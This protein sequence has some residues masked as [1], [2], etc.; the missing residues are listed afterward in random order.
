[1]TIVDQLAFD[2]RSCNL[3]RRIS[4]G[5]IGKLGENIHYG[6]FSAIQSRLIRLSKQDLVRGAEESIQDVR[7]SCEMLRSDY[8]EFG[9]QPQGMNYYEKE[10]AELDAVHDQFKLRPDLDKNRPL[11][12]LQKLPREIIT[13]LFLAT[14][15]FIAIA[16][17]ATTNTALF[18][19]GYLR[20]VALAQEAY[21]WAGDRLI[22]VGDYCRIDDAPEGVFSATEAAELGLKGP[23]TGQDSET[24]EGADECSDT[25]NFYEAL[26]NAMT[27]SAPSDYDGLLQPTWASPG[28]VPDLRIRKMLRTLPTL[29]RLLYN[30]LSEASTCGNIG[31]TGKSL[32]ANKEHPWVLCN[33]TTGEY[34]RAS[35][36][37]KLRFQPGDDYD[38]ASLDYGP[39]VGRRLTLST[40]V[41]A[42]F[43]RSSD[44]SAA[45]AYEGD[46]HR[47]VWAGHRFEIVS[48]D[49]VRP[50]GDGREWKDVSEE[51]AEEMKALWISEFGDEWQKKL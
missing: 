17:L 31:K 43:C 26:S 9:R 10:V 4:S 7:K 49:S 47:G 15:D 28:K 16:C 51:V 45:M 32:L 6:G 18:Q 40:V 13:M 44:P 23:T 39:N 42:R 50:L 38:E 1:M 30:N 12:L 19:E 3:D 37:S 48:L 27:D 25:L 41:A 5:F 20:L 24:E 33:L 8:L 36:I 29:D 34:V 11:G 46:I 14:D 35:A 22:C 21:S 2:I